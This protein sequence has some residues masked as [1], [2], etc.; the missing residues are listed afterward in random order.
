MSA[1][2]SRSYLHFYLAGLKWR[3]GG[4]SVWLDGDPTSDSNDSDFQ[5]N[6]S[7]CGHPPSAVNPTDYI[8]L[9]AAKN[10]PCHV[11]GR[12]PTSSVNRGGG[13]TSAT[14][15]SRRQSGRRRYS[16][17]P[18]SSITGRLPGRRSN[19]AGGMSAGRGRIS[20]TARCD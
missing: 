4:T 8:P 20:S 3:S 19:S 16:R 1:F 12:Q 5:Q 13:S 18:G 14:T 9:P 15:A 17:S 7:N 2:I 6:D 10:E 11:C